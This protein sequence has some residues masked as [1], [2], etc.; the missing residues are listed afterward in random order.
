M[1]VKV[2]FD[3]RVSKV[4]LKEGESN[5]R[6]WKMLLVSCVTSNSQGR[7]D[8]FNLTLFSPAYDDYISIMKPGITVI[9]TADATAKAYTAK[10]GQNRASLNLTDIKFTTPERPSRIAFEHKVEQVG[11][12][13]VPF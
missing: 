3:A 10:D 1:P 2:H 6:K 9:G 13:D 8:H 11:G 4:D 5:G 7:E 12:V